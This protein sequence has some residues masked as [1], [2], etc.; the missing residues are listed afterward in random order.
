MI[1]SMSMLH[2]VCRLHGFPPVVRR[3]VASQPPRAL[4]R[5][6]ALGELAAAGAAPTPR[7]ATALCGS[8]GN[9]PV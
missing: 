5:G 3:A 4:E 2:V 7:A 8:A 1:S 9:A 6:D